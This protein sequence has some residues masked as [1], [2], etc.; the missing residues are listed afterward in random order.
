MR[1]F[2]FFFKKRSSPLPRQHR[3]H[4]FEFQQIRFLFLLVRCFRWC[5]LF[6][7]EAFLHSLSSY[8]SL[9]VS[10]SLNLSGKVLR[11]AYL[12]KRREKAYALLCTKRNRITPVKRNTTKEN[13]PNAPR[14][15]SD[16]YFYARIF[17]LKLRCV[18]GTRMLTRLMVLA[19]FCLRTK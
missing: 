6:Q 19:R 17:T 14:Y 16:E 15:I 12:L 7:R 4:R 13:A 18:F 9:L 2:F 10:L 11:V 3:S 1:F 8:Y 5:C